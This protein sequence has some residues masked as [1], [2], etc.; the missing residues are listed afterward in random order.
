MR[1][2]RF[3]LVVA[4]LSVI[5]LPACGD[6]ED[7]EVQ[8][9][10]VAPQADVWVAS[11]VHQALTHL[12]PSGN[13]AGTVDLCCSPR[14]VVV[15][16]GAVWVSTDTG[17]LVRIDPDTHVVVATIDIGAEPGLLAG[18]DRGVWA[19]D[20]AR[21]LIRVDPLTNEVEA[22]TPV[23]SEQAFIVD[24]DLAADAVW[25]TVEPAFGLVKVD[26]ATNQITAQ[27][28]VCLPDLCHFGASAVGERGIWVLDDAAGQLLL[29]DPT[30]AAIGQRWSVGDR[31]MLRDIVA[32]SEGLWVNDVGRDTVLRVDPDDPD[33][34]EPLD[35]TISNPR[36][37]RT[38][39]GAL[40]VHSAGSGEIVRID[41]NTR[42]VAARTPT[43]QINSY[44]IG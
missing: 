39:G 36:L 29:A 15:A 11:S 10:A 5:G 13:V 24:L 26:I 37:L 2:V 44:A 28:A 4:T 1:P 27:S 34:S 9:G 7:V 12:D 25:V 38:A 32:T 8:R 42:K 30:T 35:A 21:D 23:G 19:S 43:E 3:L 40:W 18:D 31:N 22:R 20:G 33:R 6:G 14:D 17:K 41:P 16:A